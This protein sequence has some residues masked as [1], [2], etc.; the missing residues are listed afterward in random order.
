[1]SKFI[2]CSDC[3]LKL[4]IF[5][6]SMP[7]FGTI[8]DMVAPHECLTEPL[9]IV[10]TPN[11]ILPKPKEKGRFEAKLDQMQPELK[12]TPNEPGDKRAP[13]DIKSVAPPSIIN[14]IKSGLGHVEV[15]SE[16]TE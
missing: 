8:I 2:Y 5:K 6:K 11:T 15:D 14:A 7:S 12:L 10:L 13:A 9:G 1:M 16:P 3:G 4:P